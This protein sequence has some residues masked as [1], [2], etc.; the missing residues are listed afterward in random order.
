MLRVEVAGLSDQEISAVAQKG[1]KGNLFWAN[2]ILSFLSSSIIATTEDGNITIKSSGK[3]N[4]MNTD[5]VL[6]YK[7][8]VAWEASLNDISDITQ[9]E[10]HYISCSLL[11]CERN[12][13]VNVRT[14]S[15]NAR[16]YRG[17]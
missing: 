16:P 17:H 9:T 13:T 12:H 1:S 6:E 14:I 8:Q 3:P 15:H 5:S 7:E 2:L 4:Q 10:M 11:R